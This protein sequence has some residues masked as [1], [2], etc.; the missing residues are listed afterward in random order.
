[1]ESGLHTTSADVSASRGEAS[2]SCK[3]N[4]DGSHCTGSL[5]TFLSSMFAR[6][7][8]ALPA[9]ATSSNVITI[10]AFAGAVVG[11]SVV[12]MSPVVG[13]GVACDAL[14]LLLLLLPQPKSAT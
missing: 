6:S 1:M 10:A 3:V 5:E 4:S 7:A 2:P 12:V 13:I 14:L 11:G 8:L 9:T